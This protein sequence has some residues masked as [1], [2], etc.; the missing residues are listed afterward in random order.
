MQIN[1]RS[2]L[3]LKSLIEN[4][5]RDGKPVGSRHLARASGLALSAATIRNV[6]AELEELGLVDS[7]HTSAGR[8]PTDKGYRFFVDSLLTVDP[9]DSEAVS[10]ISRELD[11]ES[12]RQKIIEVTSTLLSDISHM[13]GV[14][15]LPAA[16]DMTLRHIEFVPLAGRRV[17]VVLVIDDREV[18]NKIIH[19]EQPLGEAEL[20]QAANYLNSQLG[21]QTLNEVRQRLLADMRET[22][23]HMDSMM[24]AA[25]A[26]AEKVFGIEDNDTG[27][28]VVAGQTNLMNCRELSDITR[29]RELFEVFN[30]KQRILGLLDKT[31]HSRGIQI[32]IG[33]ESGCSELDQC[34]VVTASYNRDGQPLGVLGVIG[35]MRMPYERVIP[36]VDVTAKLLGSA[37]NQ[38]G[39]S[40]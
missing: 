25:I 28:V 34:S 13:A 3:I 16:V 21:G 37:L 33:N 9:P 39:E 19:T 14:V 27:N 32:F 8:V 4:Y 36:L 17:L 5:I 6:M 35:P 26:M 23:Q 2:R 24:A 12:S 40:L 29:L 31:L 20:Q 1:E 11:P 10:R 18:Q 15:M 38:A 7:P 30:E 22:R